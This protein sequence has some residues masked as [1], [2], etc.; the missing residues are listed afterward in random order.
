M[1]TAISTAGH[2]LLTLQPTEPRE[3]MAVSIL[4]NSIT[5]DGIATTKTLENFIA[6]VP[7]GA[8]V[9]ETFSVFAHTVVVAALVAHQDMST[10]MSRVSG[11]TLALSAE[12]ESIA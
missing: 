12:T 9:A 7:V 1:A 11:V 6:V 8:W 10:V 2:L 3:T 5:L 4:A